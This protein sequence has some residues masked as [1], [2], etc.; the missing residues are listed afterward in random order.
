MRKENELNASLSDII[1]EFGNDQPHAEIKELE[2][3]LLDKS[4]THATAKLNVLLSGEDKGIEL[5]NRLADKLNIPFVL[6][7]SNGMD[8]STAEASITIPDNYL[9]E[10]SQQ[11]LETL[12]KSLAREATQT[13][14]KTENRS[15]HRL[16]NS[17]F[18]KDN[19]NYI[20]VFFDQIDFVKSDGNYIEIHWANRVSVLKKTMKS[21]E[22]KASRQAF[23]Q[24]HR[25]YL[26]NLNK[27][28]RI[29]PAHAY[30]GEYK[31]PLSKGK[32][33]Q[34]IEMLDVF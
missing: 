27:V 8:H 21:F 13:F 34:L 14:D 15:S 7:N 33:E 12:S 23:F 10:S 25:S 29:G 30:L 1:Q 22:E 24:V 6:I 18:I 31:I 11:I 3:R 2:Q 17:I 26:I 4:S 5:A 19:F 32:K 9:N 28:T 20:K 16:T